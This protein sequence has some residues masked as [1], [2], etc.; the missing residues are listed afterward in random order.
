MCIFHKWSKWEQYV[1]SYTLVR[2]GIFTPVTEIGKEYDVEEMRQ[3]R[4]CEKC[5]KMQDEKIIMG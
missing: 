4:K 3:K 2:T 5:G 1:F